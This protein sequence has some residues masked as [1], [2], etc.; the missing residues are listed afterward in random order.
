[1][2]WW[3]KNKDSYIFTS[4]WN[5]YLLFLIFGGKQICEQINIWKNSGNNAVTNCAL[6]AAVCSNIGAKI[7]CHFHCFFSTFI[8][9]PIFPWMICNTYYV[10]RTT[11]TQRRHKSKKFENLGRCVRQ[12]MLR[13]YLK[14]WDCDLVFGR[15]V[16]AISSSSV[17][18]G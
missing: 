5:T 17:V 8:S 18:R 10:S 12:N 16:R 4:F 1:M 7:F 14:I 3:L 11:D 13:P 9:S 2:I 15:A 6:R